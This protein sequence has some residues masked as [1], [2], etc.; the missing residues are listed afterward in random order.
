MVGNITEKGVKKIISNRKITIFIDEEDKELR[1][2]YYKKLNDWFYHARHYA[3]DVVNI[4][5]C[6]IVM[7]NINKSIGGDLNSKL[8]EYIS[9]SS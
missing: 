9:C 1:K 7:D 8:T 2:E 3:N 4:L 6:V 5:Q